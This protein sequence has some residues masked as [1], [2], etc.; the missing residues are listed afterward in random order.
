MPH[1]EKHRRLRLSGAGR[2]P[3]SDVRASGVVP[4]ATFVALPGLF[5]PRLPGRLAGGADAIAGASV[6]A[7]VS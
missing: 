7:R 2:E 6:S 4:A 5:C 1:P 3:R